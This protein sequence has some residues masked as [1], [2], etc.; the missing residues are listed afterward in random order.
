[1]TTI[2]VDAIRSFEREEYQEVVDATYNNIMQ[3]K[4]F[5]RSIDNN[6]KGLDKSKL[7]KVE[8]WKK[9]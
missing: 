3:A 7:N 6:N 9:I 2:N 8:E 1:M 4:Q 5:V